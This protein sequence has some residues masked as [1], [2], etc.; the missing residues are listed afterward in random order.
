MAVTSASSKAAS[1]RTEITSSDF[2]KR[3]IGHQRTAKRGLSSESGSA[4]L[5][6]T[7]ADRWNATSFPA[8]R[9][10]WMRCCGNCA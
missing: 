2:A 5:E 6:L 10:N 3:L 9:W 7:A 8:L 1:A 4:R